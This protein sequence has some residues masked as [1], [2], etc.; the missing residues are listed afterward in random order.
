M[1]DNWKENIKEKATPKTIVITVIIVVILIVL[2]V[3]AIIYY[4]NIEM[5]EWV[6]KN[7]FRK[8]VSQDN[9]SMI[10]IKGSENPNIYAFNRYI[11]ILNKNQ[12][13]IYGSSGN[14]EKKLEVEVSN[15]IF[16]SANR[17]LVMA[18][19][20]GKKLYLLTDKEITWEA[21]I[22]GNISQ[23]HVNKNGYVAVVIT[24]TSHK[25]VIA[26][27]SPEGKLKFKTYLA[28]TRTAD[29]TISNDNK[30]LAIAEVDTSGTIIQSNIKII[31]IDKASTEA[32]DSLEQTYQGE[33]DKL[34]TNIKYQDKNK[35][36][37]MYTDSIHV[38][39]NNEDNLLID[40]K[41]KKMIFQSIEL[42]NHVMGIEE[43]SS[44][45][46]TADSVVNIIDTEN[47]STKEYTVNA[48]TKDIYICSNII[49]L[50]LGTE[51]EFI[52]TDGWLVKRYLAKQ[53]I[54]N[55]VV[56]ENIAGI[57]YRDRIEI[58]NL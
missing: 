14:E 22:E 45:L 7:I 11:G 50:N 35:L 38:I 44:G 42:T 52:N 48:V 30:H 29:V 10:E 47:K 6:D 46:F 20:K 24:D 13:T 57:I 53:E 16:D 34:I 31:S 58:I 2:L 32:S 8:E 33:T 41:N 21:E 17:F 27:Y 15:P 26:M 55:I 36:I 23:V 56:S 49:A 19:K 1:I 9:V 39:E 51:I 25:T 3:I 28:S 54:T 4:N 43:K 18:E 12:F 40:N 37:C 5:R